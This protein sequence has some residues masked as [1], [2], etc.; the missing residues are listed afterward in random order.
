VPGITPAVVTTVST[1]PHFTPEQV[2]EIMKDIPKMSF[3]EAYLVYMGVTTAMPFGHESIAAAAGARAG[4][5]VAGRYGAVA[6]GVV[7][8]VAAI[9]VVGGIVTVI[10][11]ADLYAGGLA[12]YIPTHISEPFTEGVKEGYRRGP[13]TQSRQLQFIKKTFSTEATAVKKD[14]WTTPKEWLVTNW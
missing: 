9:V 14:L 13:L 8:Y 11:P 12:E 2:K 3:W 6:G 1:T 7:G 4:T 10:D 5:Q